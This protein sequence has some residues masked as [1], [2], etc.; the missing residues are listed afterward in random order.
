MEFRLAARLYLTQW[1]QAQLAFE[2][3][4]GECRSLPE[5]PVRTSRGL[6]VQ[7]RC[8]RDTC[9][10]AHGLSLFADLNVHIVDR[11]LL[12]FGG[13][14]SSLA[15]T[16]LRKF[17]QDVEKGIN[18]PT[19]T[20]QIPIRLTR[21]QYYLYKFVGLS[22]FSAIAHECLLRLMEEPLAGN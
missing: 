18:P 16:A 10:E 1:Q 2:T 20:F 21:T 6:E 14:P 9:S 12:R 15:A 19:P 7:F 8:P 22:Q 4:C 3:L 5:G 17:S 13:D 11:G